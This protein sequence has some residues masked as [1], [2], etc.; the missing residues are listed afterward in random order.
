MPR[1]S[2]GQRHVVNY[3]HIIDWLVRKPGAFR[4]YRYR[5]DLFPSLAFRRAYDALTAVCLPRTA[6]LE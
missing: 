6:D 2:G 1:V 5:D 3:R 4:Q